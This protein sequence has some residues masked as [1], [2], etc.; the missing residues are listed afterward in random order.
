VTADH[1][2]GFV[3][4]PRRLLDV[5]NP[6]QQD[7]FGGADT[8][9]LKAQSGDRKKRGGG[10]LNRISLSERRLK[11]YCLVGVY[12]AS[13]LSGYTVGENSLPNN[14]TLVVGAQGPNFPVTWNPRYA[15]A[16]GTGASPDRQETYGLNVDG[17]RNP[18]VS[19]S[20]GYIPNPKDHPDGF[21][22]TGALPTTES[23]GVHSL[24]GRV[25]VF[26]YA[27]SLVDLHFQTSQ[28]LPA[29]LPLT[30][31]VVFVRCLR[32]LF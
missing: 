8:K 31:S 29:V 32:C 14:N 24:Q 5:A 21:V 20:D 2:H 23:Q 25:I 9:Y 18:T 26:F 6:C 16:A 13:G 17:P 7:V 1:G 27:I 10:K 22:A 19:S 28:C 4:R 11:V 12:A 30:R 3:G 15:F